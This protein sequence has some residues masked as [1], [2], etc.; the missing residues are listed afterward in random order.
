MINAGKPS[1]EFSQ[2]TNI[3]HLNALNNFEIKN[4]SEFVDQLNWLL[5]EL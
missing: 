4:M 2:L 1:S 5:P 3:T